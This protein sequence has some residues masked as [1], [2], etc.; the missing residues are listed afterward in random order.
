MSLY[1]L[2]ALFCKEI[3]FH[4]YSEKMWELLCPIFLRFCPHFWHIKILEVPLNLLPL[5]SSTTDKR[6]SSHTALVCAIQ[7]LGR[8]TTEYEPF[9][10]LAEGTPASSSLC[11]ADKT[12]RRS[13]FVSFF[14][15]TRVHSY[16]LHLSTTKQADTMIVVIITLLS[17]SSA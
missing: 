16:G 4:Q 12:Q 7:F 2:F 5:S 10:N 9:M 13:C 14:F 1:I 17:R 6:W 15:T 11:G 8:L 3:E